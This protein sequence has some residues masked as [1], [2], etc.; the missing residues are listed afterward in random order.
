MTARY[1]A[2]EGPIGV[3]KTSLARDLAT[4]RQARLVLEPVDDNP[5]L[6]RF[7]GD[8]DRFAFQAQVAFLLGRHQ[9]QASIQQQDLFAPGGVVVDYLLV[10]DR[11]FAALNL[12][13]D[14][15]RLY[16]RLWGVLHPRAPKPDLVVLLMASVDV[17]LKRI[18]RRGRTYER[19]FDRA[20]LEEVVGRYAHYFREEF[21]RDY[22]DVP[23]LIVDTS[24]VDLIGDARLRERL[25]AAIDA[26]WRGLRELDLLGG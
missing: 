16:D 14:E 5:F 4:A 19:D 22:V 26:D 12:E 7:Y 11:F 23:L 21:S 9:Q 24:E 10:K 17:L 1:I 6:S 2:I 13:P 18:E 8:R 3:G 15:L 20:Y 25:Q